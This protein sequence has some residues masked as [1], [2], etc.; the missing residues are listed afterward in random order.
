MNRTTLVRSAALALIGVCAPL[1]SAEPWFRFSFDNGWHRGR[2]K[3]VVREPEVC[4]VPERPRY[5]R[6]EVLPCDLHFSAY[7]AGETVVVVATGT[8]RTAGFSTTF[9]SIGISQWSPV[10]ALCNLSAESDCV[11]QCP[12]PF[13]V[14]A[15]FHARRDLRC[16]SI[17]V[18][19]QVF[20]VP[21]TQTQCL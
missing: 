11:P 6:T 5:V 7:Q 14:S 8:N 16:F 19:G 3:V 15:S 1:A 18:A 10:L 20:E 13:S 9:G 12:T 17:R 2:A 21:V 4:R